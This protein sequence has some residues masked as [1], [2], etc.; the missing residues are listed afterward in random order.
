MAEKRM[1]VVDDEPEI[2]EFIRTVAEGKGY[3]VE[4][5]SDS[6]NFIKLYE[7]F[8]PQV[9]VMDIVMPDVDGIEL[10]RFLA[11]KKCQSQILAISGFSDRM[12]ANSKTLGQDFG[13]PFVTTMSKPLELAQLEQTLADLAV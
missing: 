4:T 3:E 12:L 7:S 8:Q 5:T 1:L 6:S 2:V 13:L 11:K 9:I 10:L